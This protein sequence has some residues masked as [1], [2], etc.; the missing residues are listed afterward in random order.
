MDVYDN[1]NIICSIHAER[2]LESAEYHMF[3]G[4]MNKLVF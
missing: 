1:I 4:N 3:S 2:F